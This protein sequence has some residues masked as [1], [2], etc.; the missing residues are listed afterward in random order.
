[1]R[2]C[3]LQLL[4][5]FQEFRHEVTVLSQ[6]CHPCIV[7]LLGVCPAQLFYAMEFAPL[8]N[9]QTVLSKQYEASPGSQ[10][11][12]PVQG[13]V[14]DRWLTYKIILQVS[15]WC[16]GHTLQNLQYEAFLL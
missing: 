12:Q 9:L 2:C 10:A 1:M 14:F 16:E 7:R 6:L 5:S 13:T 3:L 11:S 15:V 4:E 8:G